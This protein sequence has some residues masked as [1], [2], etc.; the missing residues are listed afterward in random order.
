MTFR[1]VPEFAEG[2][3]K[4]RDSTSGALPSRKVSSRMAQPIFGPARIS[5]LLLDESAHALHHFA[6]VPA[7]RINHVREH[8]Q[9]RDARALERTLDETIA[10]GGWPGAQRRKHQRPI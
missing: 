10:R 8:R 3:A 1:T 9:D 6:C 7:S 4:C 2:G 5:Q